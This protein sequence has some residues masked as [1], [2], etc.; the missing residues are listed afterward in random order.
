MS[1]TAALLMCL[2]P[3]AIDGDTVRCGGAAGATRVRIWG[4]R[5]AETGQPGA[6]EAKTALQ[7]R[8]TG[9]IVCE[10]RGASYQ[11]VV[12]LCYDGTGRDVGMQLLKVDQVVTEACSFTQSRRFPLGYY[13]TCPAIAPR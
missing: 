4:V 6:I 11:R 12:G 9:G 5:A 7:R 3:V 10:P 1:I 13:E 2:L 8:V